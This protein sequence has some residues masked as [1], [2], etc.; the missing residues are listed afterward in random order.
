[1]DM[2]LDALIADTFK[3]NIEDINNELDLRKDLGMKDATEDELQETISEYFDGLEVNMKLMVTIGDLHQMVVE[4][5]F[6]D[7]P[8]D[9]LN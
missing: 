6:K 9:Y 8:E 5:E 4:H 7:I 1:M 3:L 2:S